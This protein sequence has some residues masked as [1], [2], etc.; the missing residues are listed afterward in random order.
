MHSLQ[1]R[2]GHDACDVSDAFARQLMK[3]LREGK[4]APGAKEEKKKTISAIDTDIHKLLGAEYKRYRSV[5]AAVNALHAAAREASPPPPSPAPVSL[6]GTKKKKMSK[7][8]AGPST[9]G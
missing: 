8:T 4:K 6:P 3:K 7:K 1:I 5:H 9:T 2:P